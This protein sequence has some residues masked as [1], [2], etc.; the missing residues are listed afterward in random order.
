MEV[1][2]A[3]SSL[4]VEAAVNAFVQTETKVY[5]VSTTKNDISYLQ[6]LFGAEK[7]NSKGRRSLKI[8]LVNYS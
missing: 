3:A 1:G 2:V 8:R 4:H 6:N 7:D 5:I